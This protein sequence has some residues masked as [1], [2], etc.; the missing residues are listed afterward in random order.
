MK[1]WVN[2]VQYGNPTD[3]FLP[4]LEKGEFDFLVEPLKNY[5]FPENDS[6]ATRDEMRELIAF[7]NSPEQQDEDIMSRFIK[8]D[9]D[10]SNVYKDYCRNTIGH[11]MDESID[12]VIEDTKYVISKLKFTYQRPRP[13]QLARFYKARLFPYASQTGVSPSYP[14][15][16]TVQAYVLTEYIGSMHPEHYEFLSDLAHDVAVS[17]L[18]LGLHFSSD[19]DFGRFVAKKMVNTKEFASKYGI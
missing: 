16:H 14:S 1:S 2:E 5:A 19:N 18:F 6:D 12:K 9:S 17:R 13:Y 4:Y 7:Q 15:G 3:N 8:Y 11:N 10:L